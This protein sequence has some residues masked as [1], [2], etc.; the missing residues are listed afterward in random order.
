V[1]LASQP[2][3]QPASRPAGRPGTAKH[4]SATASMSPTQSLLCATTLDQQQPSRQAA[5]GA[6]PHTA[7]R[8]R[9]CAFS[10]RNS[11]DCFFLARGY[12]A[13]SVL[14][15]CTTLVAF[16]ST[17]AGRG[18][19]ATGRQTSEGRQGEWGKWQVGE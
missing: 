8:G 9:R 5:L 1:G 19:Q 2:A 17:Y 3:S 18:R 12:S 16:S 15:R 13:G 4:N 11:I 7:H 6:T 10:R 14:P